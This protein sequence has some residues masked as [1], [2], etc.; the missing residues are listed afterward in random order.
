MGILIGELARHIWSKSAGGCLQDA[1]RPWARGG[2]GRRR[3]VSRGR[4]TS[5]DGCARRSIIRSH[6]AMGSS[7]CTIS[8]RDQQSQ[9]PFQRCAQRCAKRWQQ[10]VRQPQPL[11]KGQRR[12]DGAR[13]A[14]PTASAAAWAE[15]LAATAAYQWT[16]V[17]Q[18]PPRG[19]CREAARAED[20]AA[21]SGARVSAPAVQ[22]NDVR[23]P[24]S[25]CHASGKLLPRRP[26]RPRRMGRTSEMTGHWPSVNATR[27]DGWDFQVLPRVACGATCQGFV[28]SREL[29]DE[30]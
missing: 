14:C 7:A 4:C 15:Q 6:A 1:R 2:A 9:R 28:S 18:R 30:A 26:N 3:H 29:F 17:A 24:A 11:G 21:A 19:R 25:R 5:R 8:A 20:A 10:R 23:G 13:R 12:R 22:S 16:A 27:Q